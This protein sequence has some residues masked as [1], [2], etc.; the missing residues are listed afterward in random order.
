[1]RK[2]GNNLLAKKPAFISPL[3]LL[4]KTTVQYIKMKHGISLKFSGF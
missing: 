2:K 1:M 4:D 3:H